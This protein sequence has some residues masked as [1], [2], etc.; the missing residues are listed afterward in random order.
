MYCSRAGSS[1]GCQPLFDKLF[2]AKLCGLHTLQFSEHPPRSWRCSLVRVVRAAPAN[3]SSSRTKTDPT[4]TKAHE[5]KQPNKKIGAPGPI[6][7]G[8]LRFRKPTLY[9][10]ELRERI[11]HHFTLTGPASRPAPT[12]CVGVSLRCRS[13]GLSYGGNCLVRARREV[14]VYSKRSKVRVK[15]VAAGMMMS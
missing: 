4:G 11:Q 13:S 2:G 6:R 14:Q 10:S 1:K 7:T 8:D 9:P 15:S 3:R 5:P 12:S